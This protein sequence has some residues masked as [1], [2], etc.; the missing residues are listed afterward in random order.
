MIVLAN[1]PGF[2]FQG[3]DFFR[4]CGDVFSCHVVGNPDVESQLVGRGICCGV[5]ACM[6]ACVDFALPRFR[7]SSV[8]TRLMSTWLCWRSCAVRS[9]ISGSLPTRAQFCALHCGRLSE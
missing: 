9:R 2:P 4:E 3:N 8:R 7:R 5:R 1:R 6:R